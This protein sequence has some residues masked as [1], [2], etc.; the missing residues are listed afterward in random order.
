MSRELSLNEQREIQI[1]ELLYLK[2]V[3]EKNNIKYYLSAGTL[4][5]AVKYQGFIPW[6]DDIDIFLIRDD[7]EKLIK[8]LENDNNEDFTILTCYNTKD[9]Y[10]PFAK[11]VSKHTKV[12]ENAKE[13]KELGVFVDIF[14]LDYCSDD[15]LLF[16]HKIRFV[17]NLATRRM[18]IKDSVAMSSL[19]KISNDKVSFRFLKDLIYGFV[20]LITLPL[21][22]NFWTR[23]L[24]K[25]VQSQKGNK[26]GIIY[27]DPPEIFD[28]NL[29][30][31]LKEYMFEG[32]IFTSIA[33]ADRYLM[34]T[35][36]DYKKDLPVYE[37]CSHHQMKAYMRDFNE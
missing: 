32:Y 22:Y 26:V 10:Y 21:G 2:D 1:K 31:S 11:L 36:G 17:R 14:P 3:C 8:I 13:I 16:Y 30:S 12:I 5:G 33:D 4:L 7:Y 20:S 29:F 23:R 25:L 19:K 35:Y 27:L 6:D 28:L 24:D 9:Y 34:D 15:V 37:Q 18:K